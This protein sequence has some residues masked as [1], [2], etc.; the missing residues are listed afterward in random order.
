[1]DFGQPTP[2]LCFRGPESVLDFLQ[3]INKILNKPRL[4][5]YPITIEPKNSTPTNPRGI[6]PLWIMYA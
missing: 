1:M 3:K 2:S 4:E 6:R 5:D